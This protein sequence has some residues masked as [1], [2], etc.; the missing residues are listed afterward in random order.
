M[1]R[2]FAFG[3]AT[4]QGSWPVQED[5]FFADPGSATFAIA[6]GFGGRGAGDLAAKQALQEARTAGSADRSPREGGILS[7]SQSAHR[8]LFG[9]INKK[10]LQWNEKRGSAKGGCSLILATVVNERELTITSCG[11]CCAFLLR[12]GN[13]LPLLSPQSPPRNGDSDPL[14]PA[15]ALGLG[16]EL[17]PE[18]RSFQWV[19]GDLLFLFSGGLAW[20]RSGFQSELAAQ[21][22]VRIPGADLASLASLA[23]QATS[24]WNQT[25]VAVEALT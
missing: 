25:A 4:S 6:D 20:E 12:A 7:P 22:A 19:P 24:A 18:S 15:Q 13:W 10:L 8:D 2:T 1:K 11:S 23:T 9:E 5:G 14:F 16:R 21:Q 17:N 3:A